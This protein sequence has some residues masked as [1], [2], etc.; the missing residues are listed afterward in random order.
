MRNKMIEKGGLIYKQVRSTVMIDGNHAD[1]GVCC[2][3]ER[4]CTTAEI[5]SKRRNLISKEKKE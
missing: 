5:K 1:S 4:K 3:T 2:S